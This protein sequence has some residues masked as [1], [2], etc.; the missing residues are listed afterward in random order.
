MAYDANGNMTNDGVNTLTY[1]VENHVLTASGSYGSGSYTYDGNGLRVQ[2]SVSGGATTVYIFSGSKVI[3]E[4]DN[5]AAPSSP[6]REYIYSGGALLAKIDSSGTKYYHQDHL[7]NRMVTDSSGNDIAD[8]GHFPYGESWYNAAGDKL[9]FTTYERDAESGNDYAQARYNVS[10]LGRFSSLDPLPGNTSD[11]QSLNRYSYVRNM[12]VMLADPSGACPASAQNTPDGYIEGQGNFVI[13]RFLISD[14]DADPDPQIGSAAAGCDNG[15]GGGGGDVYIDGGYA[16]GA[17]GLYGG[18]DANAGVYT[19][20]GWGPAGIGFLQSALGL[21]NP[22]SDCFVNSSRGTIDCNHS[23]QWINPES[24][25]SSGLFNFTSALGGWGSG[26]GGGGGAGG[27]AG[28]PPADPYKNLAKC[29]DTLYG[30]QLR[31]FVPSAPGQNGNFVGTLNG[32]TISVEN[33]VASYTAFGLGWISGHKFQS[34]LGWTRRES[35]TVNYTAS[36]LA[37]FPNAPSFPNVQL[38]E[39]AHS[40]DD[41][42]S[43]SSSE[44][45]AHQFTKCLGLPK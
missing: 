30:I 1:D 6:S 35:P 15:N 12:P 16:T 9:M 7:S 21:Y 19:G 23:A 43:G 14:S 5:G 13:A 20:T 24:L 18:D 33:D 42:T 2:K 32:K 4:Y 40:L 38:H 34:V 8:I 25:Y 41:L 3:A 22:V 27:G 17:A 45:S 44:D 10:R 37:T 28:I 31:T 26:P 36:D 29:L 11:P 39:L